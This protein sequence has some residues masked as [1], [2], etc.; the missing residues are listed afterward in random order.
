MMKK[1]VSAGLCLILCTVLLTGCGNSL[2][3]DSSL[4]YVDKKGRVISIDVDGLKYDAEGLNAFV[5]SEVEAYNEENG[6]GAVKLNDI[7]VE[8][9]IAKMKMTYQTAEDYSDF[10]G[11]E[12]YQG[13][14]VNALA[15]GYD[16]NVDF[17]RVGDGTVKSFAEKSEVLEQDELKVVII[18]ANTDVK[19]E[20]EIVYVSCEN[21]KLTGKDSVSIRAGYTLL[22][23]PETGLFNSESVNGGTETEEETEQVIQ[24]SLGS[25]SGNTELSETEE[26]TGTAAD[27]DT[28]FGTGSFET[29]VYTYIIYK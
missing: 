19:I 7:S 9:G 10:I 23:G 17:A 16:F 14:M 20:G 11:I 27:K 18:R 24:G 15:A 2:D 5:T 21:V 28:D 6:K 22:A 26:E 3:A 13:K 8:N 12:L 29:E 25:D 1:L 4:V